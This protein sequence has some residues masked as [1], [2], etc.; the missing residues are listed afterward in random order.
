[1]VILCSLVSD[2]RAMW[3]DGNQSPFPP[4]FAF[5][6]SVFFFCLHRISSRSSTGASAPLNLKDDEAFPSL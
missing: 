4:A 1:M 2:H 5:A 6:V 3:L